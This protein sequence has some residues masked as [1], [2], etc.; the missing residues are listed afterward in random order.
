MDQGDKCVKVYDPN[1]KYQRSIGRE[2]QG[3]GELQN[4]DSIH[5]LGNRRLIFMDFLRGLNFFSKE[6]RFERFLPTTY[7]VNV[8]ASPQNRIIAR[9]SVLKSGQHGKEIR[10]YDGELNLL[11][12]P[13]FF[14][15][16][17]EN[18]AAATP[19]AAGLS[20]ALDQGD[21][22]ALS[23]K[24]EYEIEVHDLQ[25]IS[26]LVI[27]RDYDRVHISKKE[28]DEAILKYRGRQIDIPDR[29][30][31]I[32]GISADDEGRIFAETLDKTK[33]GKFSF[34][35]VFDRD[36]RYLA[37]VPIPRAARSLVWKN[38]KMYSLDEDEEG[39][40]LVKRYRVLWRIPESI[41]S[42]GIRPRE[43]Q[44]SMPRRA[45]TPAEK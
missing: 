15:D 37:R 40:Q 12:T 16:A 22:I 7:F 38:K 24:P 10:V 9:V 43:L 6:G 18:P 29:H 33:D 13:L 17:L 4:P 28:I 41:E 31:A 42:A 11:K 34:Y 27:R 20:W 35:D 39:F 44:S 32:Q 1:G 23:Y 5:I 26:N 19:F 3:P 21:R 45:G 2:G 36:G 14:P 8:L 30:P 25:G